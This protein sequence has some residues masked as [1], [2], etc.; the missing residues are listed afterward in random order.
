MYCFL[1]HLNFGTNYMFR[2]VSV[3]TKKLIIVICKPKEHTYCFKY[4][5]TKKKL[6]F[7]AFKS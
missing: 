4:S 7:Y 1:R 5:F 2:N 6:K 3:D